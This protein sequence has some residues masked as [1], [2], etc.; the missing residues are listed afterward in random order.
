[1]DIACP[2]PAALVETR[3]AAIG[4]ATAAALAQRGVPVALV[5]ERH[6]AEGLVEALTARG[7]VGK[8]IL[9][10][11][12]ERARPVLSEGLETAGALVDLLPVYRTVAE[13]GD[14]RA[15]AR[16]LTAGSIDAVTFTSSSTVEHFVSLVGREAASCGRFRAAVIGPITAQTA[17]DQGVAAG[18]LIEAS[19]STTDA[20]VAALDRELGTR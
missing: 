20:L 8:R 15:L 2:D 10:P 4:P 16:E 5:P 19:P 1:V 18:G 13:G 7:V 3:V 6:V 12:A 11:T 17:R 14:G 9:V